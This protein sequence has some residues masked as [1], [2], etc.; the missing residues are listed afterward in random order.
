MLTGKPS[1]MVVLDVDPRH[2][3]DDALHDLERS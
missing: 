3:G 1:G 2:G